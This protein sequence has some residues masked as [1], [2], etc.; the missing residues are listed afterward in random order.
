MS[1]YHAFRQFAAVVVVGLFFSA[2][3]LTPAPAEDGTHKHGIA[4]HGTL[5]HPADFVHFSYTNPDA[6]KGGS[7]SLA[8]MG[9]FDTLNPLVVKGTSASG[10]R[11]FVYESLMARALDEPFSLYGLIAESVATP[12]DRGWVEFRIRDNA[13]FSDG[14]PITAKDVVFSH[15]LLKERGRPN[16]R[17]YYSKVSK[18]E[19]TDPRTVRFT[20]G[21][22]N[23]REM[24]LIMG[25]MPILPSHLIDPETFNTTTLKPPVGSGPYLVTTVEPGK[26]LVYERDPNYWGRKLPANRGRYNFA[27][28]SYEYYR[29]ASS[30][31]EGF[32]KGLNQVRFENNPGKW[33]TDYDF[34]SVKD[35]RV[36]KSEFPLGL[37]S[38]MSA[39]V[40]NTRR[41]QFREPLVRRA[42]IQLFDFEWANAN[43]FHGLYSRTKSYFDRSE[44]SSHGRP[45]DDY[46]REL[47][48][49]H[50]A[51][52]AKGILDGTFDLPQ[53][54]GT[55]RN[56]RNLRKAL[57]LFKQAGYV[58]QNGVLINQTTKQP[59]TFEIMAVSREQ[60]RLLLSYTSGLQRAGIKATIRQMEP[61]Q[62]QRRLNTFDYDMFQ[63]TW[64]ASLSPGNEQT[65]RWAT[66]QAGN[67]GSYN[68]AGVQNKAADAMIAALLAAKDRARFVSA[69]RALDR[70]L[71]SGHYV[72]PLYHLKSQWVAHWKPLAFPKTTSLFGPQ[73]DTW[74]DATAAN[75]VN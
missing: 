67:E 52:L 32:K 59:F 35:G 17:S 21:E 37:P 4:M 71:L 39:L 13:Y 47:L 34:A 33:A 54:R 50:A 7:L 24:P 38:G 61:A 18:V 64:R 1:L 55:G 49:P 53:S 2:I 62:Y 48:A 20:F 56:R 14:T 43:L 57:R 66:E 46:E 73:L 42:L 60:E 40:F 44:L 3:G 26:K 5:K 25:L 70:V 31:F 11:G 36:R 74:W 45:A 23:D 65:F 9:T 72:I 51:T 28:V 27:T 19:L 6:P 69:V 30:R 63:F 22:A 29:D 41:P 8:T 12:P 58:L 15:K 16:H 75:K 68:Y 10:I